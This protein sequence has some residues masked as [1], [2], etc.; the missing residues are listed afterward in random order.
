MNYRL[1]LIEI[2]ESQKYEYRILKDT[3]LES[4]AKME[5]IKRHITKLKDLIDR[6]DIESIMEKEEPRPMCIKCQM[7]E[8]LDGYDVCD[9]C[10]N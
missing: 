1:E 4:Q 9:D 3:I 5:V 7:Y 10:L 2:I 8:A 6:E